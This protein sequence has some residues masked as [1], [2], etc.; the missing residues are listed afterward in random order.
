M[1]QR[2]CEV[3][4]VG[5]FLNFVDQSWI[6]G[7]SYYRNL[8]DA[9]LSIP[10]RKIQPVIFLGRDTK[11]DLIG[12]SPD[13]EIVRTRILEK[14]CPENILR[15]I[16]LR[17]FSY[18]KIME[19]L[20]IRHRIDVLSHSGFIGENAR[21]PTIGWIPDFQHKRM[22]E[23]FGQK[24]LDARDRHFEQIC[25]Y[26]SCVI[27]SSDAAKR[28]AEKFYGSYISKFRVLHFVANSMVNSQGSE[29]KYLEEKYKI[30][31]PYFLL[32]NQFW[33]HKNHRTV[34]E[35]L[36]ILKSENHRILVLATGNTQDY[37]QP[38][39]FTSLL[40]LVEDYGLSDF[41][42]ILG[43]IPFNDLV[44]LMRHSLSVINPSL[45]EGWSTTVEEAKSLG[46]QI[47]LSDIPVHREQAPHGGIFFPPKDPYKLADIMSKFESSNYAVLDR[48]RINE[49][50][51]AL[52]GRMQEFGESYQDIVLSLF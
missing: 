35:A 39:Y 47:I 52:V 17:A 3:I 11:V 33:V 14:F 40:S 42:K 10:N 26:S 5:F 28:D 12:M 43:I 13:V 41:I 48:R 24:E 32:P 34:I 9:I 23:F 1:V 38:N 51:E 8:I 36:R 6:G 46:K 30:H 20:L 27:L 18:D 49:A 21:I 7:I 50:Q 29:I 2:W 45:F 19:L 25:K 37:R 31:R 16:Y 44:G 15:C 22:P 4:R